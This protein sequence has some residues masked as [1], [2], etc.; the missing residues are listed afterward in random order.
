MD[1]PPRIGD[2]LRLRIPWVDIAPLTQREIILSAGFLI[3]KEGKVV[4][5]EDTLSHTLMWNILVPS[6]NTKHDIFLFGIEIPDLILLG[7]TE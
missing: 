7:E 3:L 1:R 4:S 5:P 2:Y 6:T